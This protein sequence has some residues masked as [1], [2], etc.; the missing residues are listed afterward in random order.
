MPKIARTTLILAAAISLVQ[1]LTLSQTAEGWRRKHVSSGDAVAFN[2][3]NPNTIFT[4]LS[5]GF[6]T[7]VIV[8]Y[9]R[10]QSWTSQ[11]NPGLQ[12]VS[13]ILV[14]PSD[15]MTIFCAGASDLRKSTDGGASWRTVL[16]G[17]TIDGESIVIDPL[18]PDTM[19]AAESTEG[20]V[21]LSTD[22]GEHWLDSSLS[23]NNV[24]AL[25]IRPDNP[26]IMYAGTGLGSI[27]KSTNGGK[28]W[29][30]VKHPV[31][32]G[33]VKTEKIAISASSPLIA[34]AAFNGNVDTAVGV[35]KTTDGG[36][37]W[38]ETGAPAVSF[39]GIDVDPTD[40][41]IVF[42]GTANGLSA[43][44]YRSTDGGSTWDPQSIGLPIRGS[45][46]MI[47]IHPL[48]PSVRWCAALDAISSTGGAH[49]YGVTSTMISGAVIN[50]VSLDTV[51]NGYIVT[52]PVKDSLNLASSG[53]LYT[54]YYFDGDPS[55][56]IDVKCQA[57]PYYLA[58]TQKT[59]VEGQVTVDNLPLQELAK[60][61]IAGIVF[62]SATGA[63]RSALLR[64]KLKTSV[65]SSELTQTSDT[66]GA[67][68]FDS[69]YIS[70]PPIN[71][72][73]QLA[74]E[75][76]LPYGRQRIVPITLDSGG[77]YLPIPLTVAD[78]MVVGAADSG[79]Y[80]PYYATALES[81]NVSYNIWDEKTRG[82]A[83]MSVAASLRKKTL[84]FYTGKYHEPLPSADID[85]L[86][87]ALD[88]GC[89]LFITGQDIAEKNDTTRLL[90]QYLQTGFQASTL[91]AFVM[92]TP[93]DIYNLFG[94]NTVN[95]GASNQTSR[96]ILTP[97]NPGVK[98]VIGYGYG[99]LGIAAVRLDSV[100]GGGKAI[101]MGFGFEAI[102][103]E[104]VRIGIMRQTIGYLEGSIVLG[105]GASPVERAIPSAARLDQNYPN[106]FNPSTGI[107]YNIAER[108]DIELSVFDVTGRT[109]GAPVHGRRDPGSYV[110]TWNGDGYAS[111]VYFYRL[112]ATPV[113]TPGTPFVA[114]KMMVLLK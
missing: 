8:S 70:Y 108:S 31:T 21:Y 87:A 68:Q 5:A 72:Y 22:R 37:H 83:P 71:G 111:G 66:S 3:L 26:G 25:S 96:D 18:H 13:Q 65:G 42:A 76:E 67:F 6:R 30:V 79:L 38:L 113:L 24:S 59:F 16:A 89:K 82:T 109:V 33:A 64:L 77:V 104:E 32:P 17:Y 49:R 9:D 47:K 53:G 75:P 93:G 12:I 7:D 97:L 78:V 73:L 35:W 85:S 50:G 36:E 62:D 101:F 2:P 14:H 106:P 63:S 92:G 112:I 10:G 84:I 43:F 40:P 102:S 55:L 20:K 28:I 1:S 86:V 41:D 57:Y 52:G 88:A 90:S 48:D 103:G 105:V 54:F 107:S 100:G 99:N 58:T 11:F 114:T 39:Q 94:F 15:T 45:V 95:F 46:L 61:S 34:Y 69:L 60:R 19:H 44:I 51:K 27:S 110:E 56:T 80:A 81:I 91:I 74:I 98:T 29:R 4:S 23:V